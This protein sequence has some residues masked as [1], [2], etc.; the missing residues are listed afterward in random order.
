MLLKMGLGLGREFV[1]LDLGSDFAVGVE[2]GLELPMLGWGRISSLSESAGG[3]KSSSR[4][5][6]STEN[7]GI[8]ILAIR[9]WW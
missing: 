1:L 7:C 8:G 4:P 3:P 5:F 2:E 6:N 9:P